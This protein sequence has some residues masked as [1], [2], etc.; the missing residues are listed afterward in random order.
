MPPPGAAET[1]NYGSGALPPRIEHVGLPAWSKLV[2]A[3]SV[4]TFGTINENRALAFRKPAA[5]ITLF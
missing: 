1:A 3:V 2:V 5:R 4:P